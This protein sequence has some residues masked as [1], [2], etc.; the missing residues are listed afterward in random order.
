VIGKFTDKV[1][2]D[3]L[4][5]FAVRCRDGIAGRLPIDAHSPSVVVHEDCAGI[6]RQLFRNRQ[7][8]LH[9]EVSLVDVSKQWE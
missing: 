5:G 3:Q 2:H 1:G 8:L 6:E 9:Q 4:A 7:F